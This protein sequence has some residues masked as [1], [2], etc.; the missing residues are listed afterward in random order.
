MKLEL[1][2]KILKKKKKKNQI[3]NFINIRPVGAE[4]FCGDRWTERTKLLVAKAHKN[5]LMH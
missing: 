1:S 4:L 3:S 2:R 5:S